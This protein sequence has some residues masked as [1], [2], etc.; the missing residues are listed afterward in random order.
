MG[1]EISVGS[2][3]G[4]GSVFTV[5]IP[6][7]RAAEPPRQTDNPGQWSQQR[8][9]EAALQVLVAE[10]NAVNQLV[11]R[12]VLERFGC[13]V[14][15]AANGAEA[16]ERLVE[17]HKD[18]IFMDVQMP[19]MDGITATRAIRAL[20]GSSARTPII[21]LTAN[22]LPGQRDEYL[23]AGMDD[24]VSKPIQ[25]KEIWS[26]LTRVMAGA[27]VPEAKDGRPDGDVVSPVVAVS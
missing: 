18:V 16:V 22:A 20:G 15:I 17:G 8:M 27:M 3:V 21:A 26:A 5:T 1:G 12:K 19:V 7:S 4:R 14:T 9:S 2:E 10:D 24:Y 6:F 25:P 13:E 11:I 23:A